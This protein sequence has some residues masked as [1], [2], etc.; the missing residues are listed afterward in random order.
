MRIAT[1]V[2]SMIALR[3]VGDAN[4]DLGESELKL[5]S[6]DRINRA[7]YDPAGL[8]ISEK[9]K[10]KIRGMSQ[11]GRNVN[12]GIS[13]LQVAE[14][15]LAVISDMAIRLK[16]LAMQAATDT[17]D[18]SER[19]M[20]DTEFQ[21]LKTEISR[22]AQSTSFNS[23]L[24]LKNDGSVYDLQ[25]GLDNKAEIDQIT[26]NMQKSLGPVNELKMSSLNV[27]NKSESQSSLSKIDGL[28]ENINESRAN[29]GSVSNRMTSVMQNILVSKENISSANSKIRDTDIAAESSKRAMLD[30]RRN[31]ATALLAQA[32]SRPSAIIKLVE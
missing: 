26:Y 21:H 15:S 4:N 29:L 27:L 20:A 19:A 30:I 3:R 23:N 9:M 14:G 7:A 31:A 8:A 18:N 1:N 17:I 25:I 32:N 5:S 12:D 22:L 24:I 13:L 6:G 16:E 11:L 2:S 10:S 28:L